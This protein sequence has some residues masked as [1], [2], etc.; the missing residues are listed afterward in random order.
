[1]IYIAHMQVPSFIDLSR[2][3]PIC[4][5]Q[6]SLYSYSVTAFLIVENQVDWNRYCKWSD[7]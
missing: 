2:T 1:M 5:D 4:A 6:I 7:T 3:N